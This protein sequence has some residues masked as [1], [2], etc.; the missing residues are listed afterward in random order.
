LTNYYG[1]VAPA[2]RISQTSTCRHAKTSMSDCNSTV[3]TACQISETSTGKRRQAF[4]IAMVLQQLL[5]RL[6]RQTQASS[7]KLARLLWH[8]SNCSSEIT[9]KHRQATSDLTDKHRRAQTSFWDCNGA[10]ATACQISSTSAGKLAQ[11]CRIAM[12]L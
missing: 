7:S 1:T 12:V 9:D 8:Y 10:V 6:H 4:Q 2:C 3:A 5:V 11:A